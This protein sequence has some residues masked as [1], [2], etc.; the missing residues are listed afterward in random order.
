[1]AYWLLKTEPTDYSFADLRRDGETT[2][3]GVRNPTA[4]KNLRAMQKGDEVMIYHTGKEKAVVGLAKI[5]RAQ[6]GLIHIK[7]AKPLPHPITLAQIK[8]HPAM[9]TS[10][11]LRISRLSVVP[12][13]PAQWTALLAISQTPPPVPNFTS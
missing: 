8:A 11:L 5:A 3:E 12:L 13:A 1:M 6:E 4:V 2:W 10:P 9:Q 7:P